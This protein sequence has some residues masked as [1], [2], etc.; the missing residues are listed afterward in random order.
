[1]DLL[2]VVRVLPLAL[3]A[4]VAVKRWTAA[5]LVCANFLLRVKDGCLDQMFNVREAPHDHDQLFKDVVVL[6]SHEQICKA[7]V[8]LRCVL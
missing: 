6:V 2:V 3:L 5:G 7:H 8:G 4:V 1:M